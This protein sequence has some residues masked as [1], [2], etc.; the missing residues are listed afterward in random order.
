MQACKD[1]LDICWHFSSSSSLSPES[2]HSKLVICTR[3]A[4]ALN[5]GHRQS[6][7]CK[8]R[9]SR[10]VSIL[11]SQQFFVINCRY[12]WNLTVLAHLLISVI[13]SCS[14]RFIDYSYSILPHTWS[15]LALRVMKS[16]AST[17]S[18]PVILCGE[19][20]PVPARDSNGV[21]PMT[22]WEP[23]RTVHLQSVNVQ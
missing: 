11:W 21:N 1:I 19:Y 12:N 6:F 2:R 13:S 5:H 15:K 22:T 20:R 3:L 10:C 18:H 16:S 14:G 8:L 7:F 4:L 17:P 9:W 23:Q